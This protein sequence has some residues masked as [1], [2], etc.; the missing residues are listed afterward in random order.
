[1]TEKIEMSTIRP[2]TSLNPH[3]TDDDEMMALDP[4]RYSFINFPPISRNDSRNVR[5]NENNLGLISNPFFHSALLSNM[6]A[7]LC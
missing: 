2:A 3:L 6:S 5:A 1:M 7:S 4:E